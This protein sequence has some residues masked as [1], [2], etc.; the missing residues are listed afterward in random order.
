MSPS[1]EFL[2]GVTCLTSDAVGVLIGG[3]T[4][5]LIFGAAAAVCVGAFTGQATWYFLHHFILRRL[6]TWARFQRAIDKV[7]A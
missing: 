7:H 3:L 4:A 6:R 5:P 2:N 1:P